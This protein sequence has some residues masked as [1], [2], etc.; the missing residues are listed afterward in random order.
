[1]G[2]VGNGSHP[3]LVLIRDDGTVWYL[4]LDVNMSP[5]QQIEVPQN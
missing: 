1:M 4:V 5:I 3:S 2:P